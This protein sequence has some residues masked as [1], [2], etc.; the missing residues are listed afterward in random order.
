MGQP[1]TY[2]YAC[3]DKMGTD[4]LTHANKGMYG[5]LIVQ[6]GGVFGITRSMENLVTNTLNSALPNV[7]S[8]II[9]QVVIVLA[10]AVLIK[11]DRT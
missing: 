4:P 10:I 1:G 6:S 3:L 7:P 2:V 11:R 8:I 9:W 5:T